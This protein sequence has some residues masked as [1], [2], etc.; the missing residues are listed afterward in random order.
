MIVSLIFPAPPAVQEAPPDPA[1]VQ[2]I[3]V[4]LAEKVSVI[5]APVT[6]LGPSRFE[7]TIVY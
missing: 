7:A 4:R 6:L 1:Q 3:P 5:V 2:V